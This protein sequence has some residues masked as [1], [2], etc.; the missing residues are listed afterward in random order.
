[1]VMGYDHLIPP[2]P[3]NRE[4]ADATEQILARIALRDPA[5]LSKIYKPQECPAFLLETMYQAFEAGPL[6]WASNPEAITRRIY[7]RFILPPV[8]GERLDGILPNKV[9]V[10]GLNLFSRAVGLSHRLVYRKSGTG[11]NLGVTLYVQP[12]NREFYDGAAGGQTYLAGAYRFLLPAR[13]PVDDIVF[14]TNTEYD[15]FV[16]LEG[17]QRR[18]VDNS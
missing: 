14:E 6:Y 5:L 7:E 12:L 15:V 9:G 16:R 8:D 10:R 4:L 1:M 11:K 13:L 17:R 3:S 2:V 18:R